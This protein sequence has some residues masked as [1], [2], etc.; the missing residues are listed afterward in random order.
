MNKQELLLKMFPYPTTFFGRGGDEVNGLPADV[1]PNGEIV[2]RFCGKGVD[3]DREFFLIEFEG[4]L[5]LLR[6]CLA[7]PD[8]GYAKFAVVHETSFDKPV[9][10]IRSMFERWKEYK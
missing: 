5:F 7:M 9:L 4:I 3:S 8:S 2:D 10:Y 1:I 6:I